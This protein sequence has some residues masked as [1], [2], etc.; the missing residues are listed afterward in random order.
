MYKRN[1]PKLTLVEQQV[2]DLQAHETS[3]P[4]CRH[5]SQYRG[6]TWVC[7]MAM[8]IGRVMDHLV[9]CRLYSERD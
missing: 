2:Q 1:D 7:D 3:C 4:R 8:D 9:K 5:S 6:G